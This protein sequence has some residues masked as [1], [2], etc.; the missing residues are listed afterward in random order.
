V[1]SPGARCPSRGAA[2]PAEQ[3]LSAADNSKDQLSPTAYG[4]LTTSLAVYVR[5]DAL[6][7]LLTQSSI[8]L[9]L[10]AVLSVVLGWFV[11]G[12]EPFRRLSATR[13]RHSVGLGLSILRAIAGAHR[14]S[15]SARPE[16]GGGLRVTIRLPSAPAV[17]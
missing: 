8:I 12:F 2:L 16:P 17:P 10:C 7:E 11:A 9:V 5:R 13:G 6:H 3:A 4:A 15:A 14:G 1:R